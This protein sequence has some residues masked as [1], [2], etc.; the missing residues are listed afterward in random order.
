MPTA[1]ELVEDRFR[2]PVNPVLN[3]S[4]SSVDA[5]A[6]RIMISDADR[7][8]FLVVNLSVN[9]VYILT[10]AGVTTTRGIKIGPN[11]GSIS[12][13]WFEDFEL[14]AWEWFGVAPIGAS[15]ILV[16]EYLAGR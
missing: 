8:G 6:A 7:L 16:V 3:R 11:G 9:D 10:D 14:V 13:V 5:T 4:S 1:R 15:S 2:A 12:T